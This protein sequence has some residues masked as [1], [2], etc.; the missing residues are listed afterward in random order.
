M[1]KTLAAYEGKDITNKVFNVSSSV[2]MDNYVTKEELKDILS[3]TI[4]EI[5]GGKKDESISEQNIG[6]TVVKQSNPTSL[7]NSSNCIKY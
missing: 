6:T 7:Q 1:T 5:L 3:E 2:N 4:T